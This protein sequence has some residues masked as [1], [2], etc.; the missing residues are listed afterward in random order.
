MQFL[1]LWQIIYQT[2]LSKIFQSDPLPID[3]IRQ[4]AEDLENALSLT[5][6]WWCKLLHWTSN[7]KHPNVTHALSATKWDGMKMEASI[8]PLTACWSWDKLW[9]QWDWDIKWIIT[10]CLSTMWWSGENQQQCHILSVDHETSSLTESR[11]S[12][13]SCGVMKRSWW[14]AK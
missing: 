3:H 7:I 4:L 1:T 5:Y 6:C 9:C 2:T 12:L 10:H 11:V 14:H 8:V 13:T